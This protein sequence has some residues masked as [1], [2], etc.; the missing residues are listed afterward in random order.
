MNPRIQAATEFAGYPLSETLTD[1]TIQPTMSAYCVTVTVDNQ[2]TE[3]LRV[4]ATNPC[5]ANVIA[6]ELLFGD[7]DSV[8]PK[9]GLK[10]SVEPIA[11]GLSS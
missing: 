9:R 4:L 6:I 10:I 5:D 2:V 3:Q 1:V 11:R 7:F 8:K